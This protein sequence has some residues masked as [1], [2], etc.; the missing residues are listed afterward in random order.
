[1]IEVMTVASKQLFVEILGKQH[2]EWYLSLVNQCW[3]GKLNSNCAFV[4][5]DADNKV[6]SVQEYV[7]DCIDCDDMKSHN[8]ID[9]VAG[10]IVVVGLFDLGFDSHDVEIH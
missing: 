9:A 7:E 10:N 2:W 5:V 6:D 4:V 8:T 3:I 1:M